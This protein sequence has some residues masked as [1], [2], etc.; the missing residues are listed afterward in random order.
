VNR[1]GDPSGADHRPLTGRVVAVTRATSQASEL[2]IAL[3]ALG[4]TVVAFPVIAFEDVAFA[5]PP[6]L[7]SYE[8]IVFTSANGV[9]RFFE[10]L[11]A[12]PDS[13]AGGS[14]GSTDTPSVTGSAWRVAAIGPG[15]ARALTE[16]GIRVDLVPD[17]FVAEALLAAFPRPS[18]A[19][20][21]QGP[22]ARVLI[23]RAV[24]ARDIL[25]EGLAAL[26]Y[27]V[28]VLAV[29]RTVAGRP[30]PDALEAIASGRFDAVTF[31]SASTVTGWRDTLAATLGW[32]LP[33]S[34]PRTVSIGPIT[35]AA[36]KGLGLLVDRE[37][38]PHT[39]AGVVAA[40]VDLLGSP[41]TT[42]G[43]EE[44]PGTMAQ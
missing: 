3:E 4:A 41:D 17:R 27:E 44:P 29:Y 5:V 6:D 39:L 32:P 9:R 12:G 24:V 37:A 33:E 34:H 25:P 15:T 26:G 8:W 23:P 7:G 38:S 16:R 11:S 30:S 40:I 10:A 36:V 42:G 21:P 31:T 14:G 43:S 2:V 1:A 20:S 28:E 35:S 22:P 13:G 18:R 19:T